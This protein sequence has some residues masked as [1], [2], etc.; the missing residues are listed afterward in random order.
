MP[1]Q[2]KQRHTIAELPTL[3]LQTPHFQY[4]IMTALIK[5]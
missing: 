1:K 2:K 4:L 5:Y 3:V